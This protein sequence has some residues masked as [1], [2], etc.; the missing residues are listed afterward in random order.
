M[1]EARL[2]ST[3]PLPG[4]TVASA[5]AAY[6]RSVELLV[7]HEGRWVLEDS[8]RTD[9]AG[10]ARLTLNPYCSDG[11]WCNETADYRLR[12]DGITASLRVRFT[13]SDSSFG[14]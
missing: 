9:R 8:A 14:R 12:V 3:A 2:T 4:L 5:P 7:R 13:P 10:V 11:A 1:S 6:G